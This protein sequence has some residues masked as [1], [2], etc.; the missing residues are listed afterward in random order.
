MFAV[1]FIPKLSFLSCLL[2]C[3]LSLIRKKAGLKKIIFTPT[4]LKTKNE[5][6]RY[7]LIV[8]IR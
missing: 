8:F 3:H 4:P 1:F 5:L 2:V 7:F 6:I